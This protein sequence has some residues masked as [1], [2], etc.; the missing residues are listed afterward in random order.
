[1]T[2]KIKKDLKV[3]NCKLKQEVS[4]LKIKHKTL[5]ENVNIFQKRAES[6][7]KQM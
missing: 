5:Q 3:E 4:D 6:N 1:M 2:G 7:Y